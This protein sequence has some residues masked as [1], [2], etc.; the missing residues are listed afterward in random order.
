MMQATPAKLPSTPRLWTRTCL[1]STR[2]AAQRQGGTHR[3]VSWQCLLAASPTKH[4]AAKFIILLWF[5][6]HE[7]RRFIFKQS[8]SRSS[9][10]SLFLVHPPAICFSFRVPH[11]TCHCSIHYNLSLAFPPPGARRIRPASH[12]LL[13]VSRLLQTMWLL[14]SL[15]SVIDVCL[16]TGLPRTLWKPAYVLYALN[17]LTQHPYTSLFYL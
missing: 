13:L 10:K 16:L 12:N 9:P 8:V 2:A 15:S 17:A 1:M 3:S 11:K 6:F 4:I 5:A 7:W 14:N